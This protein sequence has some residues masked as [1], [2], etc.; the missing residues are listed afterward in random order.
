MQ[1]LRLV[2][3]RG[4]LQPLLRLST[5][6]APP[7]GTSTRARSASVIPLSNVEAQ[8]ERMKKDEKIEVHNAVHEIMKKDWRTLS[9][10]EKKAAYY[11]AFG[12]HGPRKPLNPP[13]TNWQIFFGTVGLIGL[14]ISIFLVIRS[15]APPP[16]RTMTKEWQEETNRIA[17][18][19]KQDPI[20]VS[21]RRDTRARVTCSPN[22]S[23]TLSSLFLLLYPINRLAL[24]VE[25]PR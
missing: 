10:D 23:R 11:I 18:E 4:T 19:N 6:A 7:P 17:I 14:S 15:F 24:H 2:R 13:G 21:P 3:P 9:L 25:R 16:V 1:A 22:E 5:T 20:Q 12:P 8:W